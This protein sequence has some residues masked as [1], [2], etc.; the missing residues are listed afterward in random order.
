MTDENNEPTVVLKVHYRR[1][2]QPKQYET[3]EYAAYLEQTFPG[4]L[5]PEEL[6]T[7]FKLLG[8]VVKV[9]VFDQ[10]NLDYTQNDETGIVLEVFKD[11]TVVGRTIKP[12][13]TFTAAIDAME[14]KAI[15]PEAPSAPAGAPAPPP[16][17]RRASTGRKPAAGTRAVTPAELEAWRDLE[18]NGLEN[19]WDNSQDKRNPNGPDFKAKKGKGFMSPDGRFEMGLWL[20]AKPDDIDL[21]NLENG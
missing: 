3:A 13:G 9:Q 15:P 14:A 18:A 8:Q 1:Q 10:L 19:W 7:Q 4:N 21:S 16:V 12:V 6:E 11:S 17:P 2:V 20:N 5:S